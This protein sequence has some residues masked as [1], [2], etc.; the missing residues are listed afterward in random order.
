M[1]SIIFFVVA[2][3]LC[4]LFIGLL[5]AERMYAY[6]PYRS[7]RARLDAFSTRAI[8]RVEARIQSLPK[9]TDARDVLHRALHGLVHG[10]AVVAGSIERGAHA[11][12]S[13]IAKLEQKETALGNGSAFLQEVTKH[14]KEVA[15]QARNG[16][17]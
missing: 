3:T 14:K 4:A 10:V 11:L 12:A 5:L 17:Q 1:V 13:S 7:V 2:L 8:A 15:E 9:Q 16:L 6:A